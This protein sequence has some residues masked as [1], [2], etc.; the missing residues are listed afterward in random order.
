MG[1]V[2]VSI[3]DC[4]FYR[5]AEDL[6][7]L[8]NVEYE[9]ISLTENPEWRSLH[10]LLTNGRTKVPWIFFNEKLIGGSDSLQKLEDEGRLDQLIR[11]ALNEHD[12]AFPPPLRKPVCFSTV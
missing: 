4:P 6:L 12:P 3:D 10:F 9:N 2:T 1:K 8:K 7:T 11:E 5:K